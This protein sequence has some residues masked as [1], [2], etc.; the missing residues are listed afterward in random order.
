MKFN[1]I[2][3]KPGCVHTFTFTIVNDK[4]K[5]SS[6]HTISDWGSGGNKNFDIEPL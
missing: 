2:E 4:V 1:G 3:L 5:L 6:Q